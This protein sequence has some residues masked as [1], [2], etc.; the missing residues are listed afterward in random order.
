[1][2]NTPGFI[3]N[4]EEIKNTLFRKNLADGRG[5]KIVSALEIVGAAFTLFFVS[6]VAGG[7]WIIVII[8]FSILTLTIGAYLQ[9]KSK[10]VR[11]GYERG[12]FAH[13]KGQ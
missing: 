2:Q 7:N 6:A 13:I 8:L 12:Y 10:G 3:H 9:G 4:K 1:M 11:E 5:E